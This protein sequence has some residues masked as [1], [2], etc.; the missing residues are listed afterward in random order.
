MEWLLYYAAYFLTGLTLKIGD[1]FLDELNRPNAAVVPLAVSGVLFGQIMTLSEWD[2]VLLS[3]IVLG[4][5]LSG[6]VNKPQY[7]VGFIMIG[8]L[9]FLGGIPAISN[10]VALFT[11]LITLL[12][13]AIVDER[14]NDW[15]D[16]GERQ[17]ISYFFYY[18]F[19]LKVA[20]ILLSFIWPDFFAAAVGLW[21]FDLGYELAGFGVSRVTT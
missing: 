14:G 21:L 13:A 20:V 10:G 2:L 7:L 17:W 8:A 3:A 15:A 18:R 5:L 12:L 19:T 9:L 4:V 1:D 11:L 6:K 16:S